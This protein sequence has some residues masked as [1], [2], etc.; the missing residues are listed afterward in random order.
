LDKKLDTSYKCA[1]GT[2]VSG[3]PC[4]IQTSEISPEWQFVM[5]ID[6][7]GE[8]FWDWGDCP[9]LYIFRHL[10]TGEFSCSVQMF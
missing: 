1:I 7:Y 6:E 4:W 8:E 3:W 5:Q 9:T 10:V 2:K